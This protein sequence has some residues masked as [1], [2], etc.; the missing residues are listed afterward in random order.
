MTAGLSRRRVLGG[1]ALVAAPALLSGA[2][3][4]DGDTIVFDVHRGG[5]SIGSHTLAFGADGGDLVVDVSIALK[6]TFASITLFRYHH[7]SRERWRKG[8]LVALD[9]RTDDDGRAFAV[10]ARAGAGGLVVEGSEG[11]LLLDPATRTTSYWH[12]ATVRQETLLDTQRGGLLAL[13]N[14]F[15]GTDTLD[16]AGDPLAADRYD[17][18]GDLEMTLWYGPEGQWCGLVFEARGEEVRYHAVTHL[19]EER[20]SAIAAMAA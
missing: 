11:R 4:A 9:S 2:A 7:V 17:I 20:W 12:P 19:P 16:V 15:G 5:E 10:S 3:R 8:R 18:A 14:R 1:L 13:D 6:V